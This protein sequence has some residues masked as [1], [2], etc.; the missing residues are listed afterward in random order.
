MKGLADKPNDIVELLE[1]G[2]TL[3]DVIDGHI[4]EQALVSFPKK[5][6]IYFEEDCPFSVFSGAIWS[7]I[8]FCT[9]ANIS[10]IIFMLTGREE[11]ICGGWP[12][13]ADATTCLL[14]EHCTTA[15]AILPSQV[16]QQPSSPTG[17]G[18]L[19]PGLCL[20]KQGKWHYSWTIN[21]FSH[22][23]GTVCLL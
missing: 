7:F 22:S 15:A 1:G 19:G 4:Y 13:C 18:I 9:S 23:G 12:W 20:H 10:L 16:Q 5:I 3:E 8:F 6:E 17:A 21:V 14:A 11:C 2:V